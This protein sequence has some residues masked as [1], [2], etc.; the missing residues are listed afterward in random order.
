[1]R[2]TPPLFADRQLDSADVCLVAAATTP[3]GQYARRLAKAARGRIRALPDGPAFSHGTRRLSKSA[4]S[5]RSV[6]EYR[7]SPFTRAS[8]L[9]IRIDAV[10]A[11]LIA[12]A[13]RQEA[14]PQIS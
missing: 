12:G 6:P 11:A 14:R 8:A 1:M 3:H 7:M 9:A 5:K 10:H 2:S 4:R 13:W